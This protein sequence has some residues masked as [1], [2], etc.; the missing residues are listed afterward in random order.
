MSKE[1]IDIATGAAAA[2]GFI[3]ALWAAL[4]WKKK[5]E[6]DG[7]YEVLAARIAE[8]ERRLNQMDERINDAFDLL[9]DAAKSM[10]SAQADIREALSRLDERRRK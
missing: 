4:K 2:G 5:P 8:H 10:A 1:G 9:T 3:G 6:P 7:E